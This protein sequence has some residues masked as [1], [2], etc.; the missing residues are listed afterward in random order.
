MKT[1]ITLFTFL[2]FT[3]SCT[4]EP[5]PIQYG[6]DNCAHCQMKI[7]DSRFGTELVTDKGKVYKFDSIECLVEYMMRP[8]REKEKFSLFLVTP[9]NQPGELVDAN[10][11]FFL[12]SKNLPS[13]MGMYLSA[14]KTKADADGFREKNDGMVYTWD[15]LVKNFDGM[16][17]GR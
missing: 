14:F 11:S 3:S 1:F 10:G 2:L 9:F 15:G 7:M 4:I 12:H 13:P 6:E 16:K 8:A 5:D 17:K